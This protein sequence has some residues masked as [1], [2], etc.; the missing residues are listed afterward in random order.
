MK[1]VSDYNLHVQ[2]FNTARIQ[3]MHLFYGHLLCGIIEDTLI[4]ELQDD[5]IKA[6]HPDMVKDN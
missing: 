4:S 6:I 2:S 3:E 5:N 1:E